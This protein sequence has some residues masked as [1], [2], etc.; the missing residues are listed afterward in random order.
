MCLLQG[1]DPTGTGEGGESIFG[2]PF[3]DE[4][5]SRLRFTHRWL[6]CIAIQGLA[7]TCAECTGGL[8][9]SADWPLEAVLAQQQPGDWTEPPSACAAPL[10]PVAACRRL[11]TR[12]LPS[13]FTQGWHQLQYVH[14]HGA[15]LLH[16]LA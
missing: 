8:P 15:V 5:H 6:V 2:H 3:K 13:G 1:G 16:L 12:L 10:D 11:G 4:F 9:S 14:S 7:S